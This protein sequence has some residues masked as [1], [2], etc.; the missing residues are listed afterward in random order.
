[1]QLGLILIMKGVRSIGTICPHKVLSS[2]TSQ[3]IRPCVLPVATS[4]RAVLLG[5]PGSGKGTYGAKLAIAF[6]EVPIISTGDLLRTEISRGSMVGKEVKSI[7]EA[8]QLVSDDLVMQLL[9][10][11]LGDSEVAR[12]GYI[13]DGFPRTIAQANKLQSHANGL[14]APNLVINIDLRTEY[15]IKKL[16]GRRNCSV[17]GSSFNLATI[18]EPSQGYDMPAIMCPLPCLSQLVNRADDTEAVIRE[19]LKVY[20]SQ[21]SPLIRFYRDQQ[22]L[23]DFVVKKGL[24]DLPSFLESILPSFWAQSRASILNS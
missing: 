24:N 19:R 2:K 21:T 6:G 22:I 1:M 5:A 4:I 14:F 3:A 11:K 23:I 10:D 20:E 9:I 13:L 12:K 7:L 17:C 8:G 15:I 16:L 18:Y